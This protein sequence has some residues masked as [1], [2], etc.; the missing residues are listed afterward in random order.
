MKNTRVEFNRKIRGAT[1][2]SIVVDRDYYDCVN[3]NS[4]DLNA[5]ASGC[6]GNDELCLYPCRGASGDTQTAT[7]VPLFREP[8]DVEMSWAKQSVSP[9]MGNGMFN[10]F[11]TINPDSLLSNCNRSCHG[12][13]FHNMLKVSR[14]YSTFWDTGKKTPLY[15][16]AIINLLSAQRA[17]IEIPANLA[18]KLGDFIIIPNDGSA[19]ANEYSGSWLVAT[20]SHNIIGTQNYTMSIGLIRDSKIPPPERGL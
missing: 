20:I 2:K 11:L 13:F 4:L 19:I 12:K 7:A 9:C 1:Q 8:K 17:E 3:A 14:T 18:I 16:N 10:G 15:R 5:G 6:S